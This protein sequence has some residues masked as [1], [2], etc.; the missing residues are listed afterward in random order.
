M[1][2]FYKVFLWSWDKPDKGHACHKDLVRA[3]KEWKRQRRRRRT[4]N[5]KPVKW[6]KNW[7]KESRSKE[8]YRNY[9]KRIS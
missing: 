4:Y 7:R 5:F 2:K 6:R 8:E 3:Q 1:K 9:D